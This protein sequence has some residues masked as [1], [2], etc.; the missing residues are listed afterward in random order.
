[1]VD[2][3]RG[4]H[5]RFAHPGE[6]V[7]H[8]RVARELRHPLP[9]GRAFDEEQVEQHHVAARELV[10][11][12]QRRERF[13]DA[14]ASRLDGARLA[15]EAPEDPE[16]LALEE[17]AVGGELVGDRLQSRARMHREFVGYLREGDGGVGEVNEPRGRE[18]GEHEQREEEA[19]EGLQW[20]RRNARVPLVPP[21]P[22]EFESAA[23]IFISRAVLAT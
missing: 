23:S 16:A 2:A 20:K 7:A 13:V 22:K 14:V 3:E 10:E 9:E 6:R 12:F 21:N 4:A 1:V 8:A 19:P 17:H 15:G 18:R 11:D 5:L